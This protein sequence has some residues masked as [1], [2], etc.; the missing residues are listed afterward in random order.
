M[1][2]LCCFMFQSHSSHPP[3]PHT[4]TC[5]RVGYFFESQFHI[6]KY[7]YLI[8]HRA[9]VCISNGV[10]YVAQIGPPCPQ[11]RENALR[12]NFLSWWKPTK[13]GQKLP[14]WALFNCYRVLEHI[15][16]LTQ[17]QRFQQCWNSTE[18]MEI[19]M[20]GLVLGVLSVVR[21]CIILVEK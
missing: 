14:F 21:L 16:K 15:G 17:Q 3:P 19:V 12:S 9:A 13:W 20:A 5:F 7:V 11:P 1:K 4:H 2:T 6:L 8:C 10:W 18:W